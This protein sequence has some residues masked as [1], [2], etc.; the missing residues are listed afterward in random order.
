MAVAFSYSLI[1]TPKIGGGAICQPGKESELILVRR[2]NSQKAV[3]LKSKMKKTNLILVS[4]IWILVSGSCA[5]IKP[6]ES[7]QM[8]ATDQTIGLTLLWELPEEKIREMLPTDQEPR[9]ENGKG[10]LML[11]LT[12]TEGYSVGPKKLGQLGIAHL[13]IPLKNDIAIPET[14]GLRKQPIMSGLKEIGF[15]V[16]FGEV[17]LTL[18]EGGGLVEVEG[19][20]QFDQGKLNLSGTA[21]NKK[22]NLV[23]L[24]Q[25]TLIGSSI[26]QN[27]L[28][29][30]ESYRPITFKTIEMNHTGDTWIQQIGLTTPPSRIW[31]NVDFGIDFKYFKKHPVASN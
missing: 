22:E 3:N 17:K 10:V 30:P 2:E 29:G 31:V 11:F 19:S 7:W 1:M 24:P 16:K 12:S 27:I 15:T 13:I 23:N 6:G 5:S 18:E 21:E 25:T 9:I 20:I 8:L 14:I 28:S 4:V 26:H